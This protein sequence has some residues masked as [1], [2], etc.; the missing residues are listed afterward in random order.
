MGGIARLC[1]GLVGGWLADI[2]IN[3]NKNNI[4]NK[5]PYQLPCLVSGLTSFIGLIV[6]YFGLIET[7]KFEL[8]KKINNIQK[9]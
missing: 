4:F 2:N 7:K 9:I 3:N 5:F 8:K 1:G 6:V